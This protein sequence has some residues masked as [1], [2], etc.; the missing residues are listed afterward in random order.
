MLKDIEEQMLK[1]GFP[2][3]PVNVKIMNNYPL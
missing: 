1:T 2:N 3:L